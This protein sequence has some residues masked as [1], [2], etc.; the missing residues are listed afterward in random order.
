MLFR[1]SL[2]RRVTNE[3]FRYLGDARFHP[4]GTK[5]VATKWYTGT[6]S[7]GAGEGWEYSVPSL[8]GP[9][10]DIPVG[11]GTRLVGRTLPRGWG[12]EDYNEQQIGPEQF[13]W[14]GEDS[15]IYSKNTQD[16][17]QFQYSKG[18]LTE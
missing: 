9:R 15:L 13:I 1:R 16:E 17:G 8:T 4:S 7:V 12:T 11:S 6:R 18:T 2:A 5:V 14:S 3:T 10:P